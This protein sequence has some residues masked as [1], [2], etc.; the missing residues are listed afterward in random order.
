MI[1]AITG[2]KALLVMNWI[3]ACGLLVSSQLLLP[4]RNP[5]I[6]EQ[7]LGDESRLERPETFSQGD[8]DELLKSP[9]TVFTHAQDTQ[10]KWRTYAQKLE[11]KLDRAQSVIQAR[12]KSARRVRV[13]FRIAFGFVIINAIWSA[14]IILRHDPGD[15]A[16]GESREHV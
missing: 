3:A 15:K 7:I 6:V 11:L 8:M 4:R 14:A 2:T 10:R 9:Y 16:A 1:R 13:L 5:I 12:R